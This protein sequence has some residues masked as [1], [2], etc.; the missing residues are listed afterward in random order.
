MIKKYK[1]LLNQK[2]PVNKESLLKN[3][4]KAKKEKKEEMYYIL[5]TT[6]A[7]NELN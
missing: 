7:Y 4:K 3:F 2:N 1:K 6:D 5:K